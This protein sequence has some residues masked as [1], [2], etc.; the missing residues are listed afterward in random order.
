MRFTHKPNYNA[1]FR[2]GRPAEDR[3]VHLNGRYIGE[4]RKDILRDDP[5]GG[6]LMW[7]WYAYT[8][9]DTHGKADTMD[10]A[11]QQLKAHVI[12]KVRDGRVMV[13]GSYPDIVVKG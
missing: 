9:P 13:A 4:V 8:F 6:R 2:G 10:E 7:R 5:I 3:T 1:K 12:S 11:L